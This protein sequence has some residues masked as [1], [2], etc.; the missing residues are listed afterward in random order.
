MMITQRVAQKHL[1]LFWAHEAGIHY[2]C[3]HLSSCTMMTLN[4]YIYG[5]C[6]TFKS[7]ILKYIHKSWQSTLEVSYLS[8]HHM[9]NRVPLSVEP[10]VL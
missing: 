6:Y 3:G 10:Y 8:P 4:F 2:L 9:C 1:S 7:F 5:L